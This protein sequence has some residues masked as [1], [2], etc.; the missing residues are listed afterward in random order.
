MIDGTEELF[1]GNVLIPI[2]KIRQNFS[3]YR[4]DRGDELAGVRNWGGRSYG[5]R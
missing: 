3:Y 2:T 1:H 4:R 5:W